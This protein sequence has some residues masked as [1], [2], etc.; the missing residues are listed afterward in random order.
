MT[1]RDRQNH[2]EDFFADTRMTFGE[3]LED[4]RTHLWRAIKGF[5]IAF[6]I[7]FVP[8]YYVLRFIADPVE[9]QIQKFYDE[10]TKRVAEK[11]REGNPSLKEINEPKEQ[12]VELSAEDLRGFGV[13]VLPDMADGGWVK[14]R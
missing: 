5:L 1:N 14:T 10:R 4:L 13:N 2:D 8:G 9:K 12:V 6:L 7:S 11:L 3:H